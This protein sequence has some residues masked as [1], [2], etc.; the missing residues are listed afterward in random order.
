MCTAS[1]IILS[2]KSRVDS[3][4]SLCETLMTSV[5]TFSVNLLSSKHSAF[6]YKVMEI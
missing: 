4:V 6:A 3:S 5:S 2:D 1:S